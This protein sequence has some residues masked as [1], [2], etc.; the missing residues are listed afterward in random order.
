[1]GDVSNGANVVVD[2]GDDKPN[3]ETMCH[4]GDKNICCGD[5]RNEDESTENVYEKL[6]DAL[7][8]K[9]N[10]DHI[11]KNEQQYNRTSSHKLSDVLVSSESNSDKFEF[12]TA[13]KTINAYIQNGNEEEKINENCN[14]DKASYSD[15]SDDAFESNTKNVNGY[16][17]EKLEENM[18]SVKLKLD[19]NVKK[20]ERIVM[21]RGIGAKMDRMMWESIMM[22]WMI[23]WI[24]TNFI[25][26]K[27]KIMKISVLPTM[28]MM[29]QARQ[30]KFVN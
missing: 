16:K 25:K 15:S 27:I 30:R 10:R 17:T 3:N 29:L 12:V 2:N 21:N 24:I 14:D 9:G 4:D 6:S 1:M 7:A 22:T 19:T 28:I 11:E 5:E 20:V 23:C 18:E 13:G 8:D 26:I